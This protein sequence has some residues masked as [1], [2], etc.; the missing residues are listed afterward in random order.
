M[1]E[2]K[3]ALHHEMLL[4]Y[5]LLFAQSS[6][7]R[8]IVGRLLSQSSKKAST[9]TVSGITDDADPFLS[10]ICTTPLL[11]HWRHFSFTRQNLLPGTIFPPSTLDIHGQ[12]QECDTYSARDDFPVFGSRL[13]QLQRYNMRQ[14]PS[15][16]RDLWRD[17]R[18][19]LQ[20]YTFWAVLWI[21]GV[22]IILA[23]LQLLVGIV[24][25]YVSVRS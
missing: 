7:S 3:S 8:R 6:K 16:V 4:S 15:R 14:Q 20:W 24:Q 23:V 1:P 11:S 5:R 19:P 21:G 17:R 9:H 25:I 18:N 10:T 2:E 13:L 12:L 22:T